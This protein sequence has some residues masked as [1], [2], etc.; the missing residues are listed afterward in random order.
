MAI[1][2]DSRNPQVIYVTMFLLGGLSFPLYSLCL[3][4]ANDNTDLSIMEVG[5]GVLMMNSIGS[6][7]G[8]LVCHFCWDTPIW[9]RLLSQVQ[10]CPF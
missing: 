9:L 1:L 7:L 6:I 5:S 10:Q 3:A 2:L 4:H 8:P